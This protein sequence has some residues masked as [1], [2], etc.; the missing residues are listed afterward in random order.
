[1]ASNVHCLFNKFGFCKYLDTCRK[2]HSKDICEVPQCKVINCHKRHPK[3]CR[4]YQEYGKCKFGDYC[5]YK[6]NENERN[7]K[8]V[9]ELENMKERL[10]LVETLLE[11]KEDEIQR[12]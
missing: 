11:K 4:F 5:C 9:K 10:Q 1:M 2:K 7:F 12:I 3:T 6:H 8:I